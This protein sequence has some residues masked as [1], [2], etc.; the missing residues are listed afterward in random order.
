MSNM[1]YFFMLKFF[2]IKT[3]ESMV[4]SFKSV[5]WQVLYS[6]WLKT[7]IDGLGCPDLATCV[8]I[9]KENWGEDVGNF[10]TFVRSAN[11]YLC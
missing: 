11:I 9:L 3:K 2:N 1:I 10:L 5:I 7:N 6:N 8:G 4:V